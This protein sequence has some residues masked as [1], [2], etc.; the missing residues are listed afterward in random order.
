M[1]RAE[2][3][4][5]GG[6]A[7]LLQVRWQKMGRLVGKESDPNVDTGYVFVCARARVCV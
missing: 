2:T 3:A 1:L 4:T 6:E 7:A 5:P